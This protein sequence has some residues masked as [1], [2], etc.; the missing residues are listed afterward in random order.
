M[1]IVPKPSNRQTVIR[2]FILP[3]MIAIWIEVFSFNRVD[4]LAKMRM[5]SAFSCRMICIY[6]K[7]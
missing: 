3:R 7:K 6:Q 1:H 2:F 5:I 4:D